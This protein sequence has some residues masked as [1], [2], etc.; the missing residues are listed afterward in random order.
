MSAKKKNK[1]KTKKTPKNETPSVLVS[2]S[3][4]IL[5]IAK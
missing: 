1:K 5:A 4:I 3:K 2:S